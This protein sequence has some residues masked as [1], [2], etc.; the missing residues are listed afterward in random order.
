MGVIFWRGNTLGDNQAVIERPLV[1]K[2]D[3]IQLEGLEVDGNS[4]C[5]PK[6][7]IQPCAGKGAHGKVKPEEDLHGLE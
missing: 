6:C 7:K 5:R 4:L 3:I 2:E 1:G